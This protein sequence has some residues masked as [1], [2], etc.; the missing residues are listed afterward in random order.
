MKKIN[1]SLIFS[2]LLIMGVN[3][4]VTVENENTVK[5]GSTNNMVS[6]DITG[7]YGQAQGVTFGDLYNKGTLIEAG[8]AES[9]GIYMDGDKVVIWS[10]GD[11]NLVNFCDEDLMSAGSPFYQAVIAYIDGQGYFYTN[12]DSIRKE[13]IVPIESALIKIK[14]LRGVEYYHKKNSETIAKETEKGNKTSR[15]N[16]KKCGFLAQEVESI[17]PEAVSTNEANIKFINYQAII[18]YL[19]EAMKE[20]QTQIGQLQQ[21]NA[22]IKAEID[23]IKQALNFVK[24]K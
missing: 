19:V 17:I 2:G 21:E 22:R 20:Q 1:L 7:K 14:K 12:S 3:A 9:G 15:E 8:N 24:M 23:Q 16:A 13:Q 11:Q 18:P 10:P 4:Q 5:L 6:S